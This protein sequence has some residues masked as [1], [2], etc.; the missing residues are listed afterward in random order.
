[1][2]PDKGHAL[3]VN[4]KEETW[5]DLEDFQGKEYTSALLIEALKERS[6]LMVKNKG[7]HIPDMLF[8]ENNI[9]MFDNVRPRNW[10][11][12][13]VPDG[14][15]KYDMVVIGGGAAGMVTAAAA[16]IYGAKACMIERGFFGGDCLVT[17]CVPSKAFLKACAVAHTVKNCEEYGISIEGSVNIDFPKLMNK[18]KAIRAEISKA[19]AAEKFSKYYGMDVFLGHAQFTSPNTVNINGKELKFFRACIATGA[20]PRI[21]DYPGIKDIKYYTSDNIFNL[22]KLPESMLIIGVGP[23]GCELGQGFARLGTRVKM[24]SRSGEFLPKDDQDAVQFLK[25]QMTK[26]GVQIMH[27]TQALEF[28]K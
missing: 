1:M 16:S 17:G 10:V 4:G 13:E 2:E 6:D 7:N 26:D 23:I 24:F 20:R 28:K 3:L 19:D 18:M 12:P 14:D 21:P 9:K 27:H 11:D 8:D 15:N 5:K 25:T 22:T